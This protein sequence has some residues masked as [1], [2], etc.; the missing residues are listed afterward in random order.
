M[1]RTAYPYAQVYPVQIGDYQDN[2]FDD[3]EKVVCAFGY[4]DVLDAQ[5]FPTALTGPDSRMI[6][7][8][9]GVCDILGGG[10]S[11]PQ[12]CTGYLRVYAKKAD[13][14]QGNQCY[15]QAKL[16]FNYEGGS[17]GKY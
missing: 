5:G 3:G 9:Y 4:S 17:G 13:G 1:F 16:M 8:E 11:S 2:A 6:Y 10:Y 12:E 14:T 7:Q 15:G